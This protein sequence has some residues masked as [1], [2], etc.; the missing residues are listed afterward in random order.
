MISRIRCSAKQLNQLQDS[1]Y[2]LFLP[3]WFR[4]RMSGLADVGNQIGE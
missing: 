1:Y 3:E 2:W 4:L